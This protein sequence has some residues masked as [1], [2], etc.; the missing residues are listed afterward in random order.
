[1]TYVL[2]FYFNQIK[3]QILDDF[4]QVTIAKHMEP[5]H[6]TVCLARNVLEISGF[7]FW[8]IKRKLNL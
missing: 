7:V 8:A 6:S 4:A 5:M 2:L 1:M 3:R